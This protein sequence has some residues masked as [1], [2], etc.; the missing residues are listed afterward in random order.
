MDFADVTL[1][2]RLE[3]EVQKEINSLKR[4]Y[5]NKRGEFNIILQRSS[6]LILFDKL[7][8]PVTGRACFEED[9]NA[10]NCC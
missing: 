4:K 2:K 5:T 3:K 9:Q 7:K 10:I 6:K 1:F 8:I